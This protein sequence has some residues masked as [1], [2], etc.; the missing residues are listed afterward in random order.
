MIPI[1]MKVILTYILKDI[2]MILGGTFERVE[3]QSVGTTF[4]CYGY[5]YLDIESMMPYKSSSILKI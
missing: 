2:T 4:G 5:D 3:C 1:K